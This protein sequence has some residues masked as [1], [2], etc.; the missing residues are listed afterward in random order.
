MTAVA[1]GP[2]PLGFG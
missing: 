2:W 1:T